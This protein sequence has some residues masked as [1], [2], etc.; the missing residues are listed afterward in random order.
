MTN[1]LIFLK[2]QQQFIIDFTSCGIWGLHSKNTFE[3]NAVAMAVVNDRKG[4]IA[5]V[6]FHN[7]NPDA[8]T[9]E[10]S[11]Y[12]AEKKWLSRKILNQILHYPFDELGLRIVFANFSEKQKHIKHMAERL[13]ATTHILPDLWGV[14]EAKIV[15]ILKAE[16]WKKSEIYVK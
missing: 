2:D 6:I 3:D 9:I 14:D 10:F 15:A 8:G 12:A 11:C 16:D 1:E 13:G 5:G 4:I 7:Y